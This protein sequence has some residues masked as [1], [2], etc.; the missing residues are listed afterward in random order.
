MQYPG[1]IEA[2]NMGRAVGFKLVLTQRLPDLLQAQG[3]PVS[4]LH[5]PLYLLYPFRKVPSGPL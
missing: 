5:I 2:D 1:T 3:G 4:M